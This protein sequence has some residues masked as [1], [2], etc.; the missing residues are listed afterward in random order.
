MKSLLVLRKVDWWLAL[1]TT[2]LCFISLVLLRSTTQD[3]PRFQS[4][5]GKQVLFVGLS[6]GLGFFGLLVHYR[7]VQRAAWPL[8]EIGRAHV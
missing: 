6:L 2:A 3:D 4:Q 8:W 1:V 7:R 5:F